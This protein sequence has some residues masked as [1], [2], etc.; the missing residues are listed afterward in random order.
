MSY[1]LKIIKNIALITGILAILITLGVKINALIPWQY[2]TYIF[3][4]LRKTGEIFNF[5]FDIPTL[6]KVIPIMMTLGIL[7]WGW[8]GGLIIWKWLIKI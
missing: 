1:I 8:V 2:L 5:M 4:I 3:V 6:L 7:Y